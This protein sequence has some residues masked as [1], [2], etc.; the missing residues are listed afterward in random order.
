MTTILSV[1]PFNPH[2]SVSSASLGTASRRVRAMTKLR[3]IELLAMIAFV[4][5]SRFLALAD[6]PIAGST[7]TSVRRHITT[8]GGRTARARLRSQSIVRVARRV[9]RPPS[10]FA[11]AARA[12]CLTNRPASRPLE[13][14]PLRPLSRGMTEARAWKREMNDYGLRRTVTTTPLPFRDLGF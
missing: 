7:H 1:S 11:P 2:A 14:Y 6:L 12:D 9:A 8:R 5:S 10:Q 13:T 3:I 4:L